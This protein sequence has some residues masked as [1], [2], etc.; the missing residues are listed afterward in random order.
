MI[1]IMS[2]QGLST[3]VVWGCCEMIY[4]L[5]PEEQKLQDTIDE[6]TNEIYSQLG[7]PKWEADSAVK[8]MIKTHDA[9]IQKKLKGEEE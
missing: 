9:F 5:T 2:I 3:L 8:T 7:I 4:S 6:L 1:T